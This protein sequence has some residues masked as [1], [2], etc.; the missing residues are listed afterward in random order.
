MLKASENPPVVSPSVESLTNLRGR[1][2]VAHTKARC[3][4]AF[5]WDLKRRG[6]GYFL[7]MVERVRVSG[8]RKRRAVLP[9]FPSYVFLC[10]TQTDRYAA[11]TTN[12]LCATLEVSDQVR[13]IS[14]LSAIEKVLAGKAEIDLYPFAAEGQRCR[15]I[16]GP[17]E[18]I[19]GIVIHRNKNARFVLEISMLGRGAVLEIAG[20][21]LAPVN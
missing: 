10:G 17:F 4:K 18:D 11:M 14:E 3:E 12:R 19:E 9:L 13:L 6:I 8:G 2:W 20:D 16:A 15:V 21:L 7:P 5:A 1:W